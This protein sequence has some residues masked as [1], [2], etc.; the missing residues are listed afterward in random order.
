[1]NWKKTEVHENSKSISEINTSHSK[2]PS[3]VAHYTFYYFRF[4]TYSFLV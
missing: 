4:F 1:M 3:P 2:I